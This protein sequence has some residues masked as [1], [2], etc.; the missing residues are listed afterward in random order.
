[1]AVAVTDKHVPSDS[2]SFQPQ[3]ISSSVRGLVTRSAI[4]TTAKPLDLPELHAAIEMYAPIL[5]IHPNE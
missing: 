5:K 2:L 1:M 3:V 4:S